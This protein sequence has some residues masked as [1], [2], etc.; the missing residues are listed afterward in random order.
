[1][2]ADASLRPLLGQSNHL[3][4]FNYPANGIQ[5]VSGS[6]PLSSTKGHA[7]GGVPDWLLRDPLR[8]AQGR[9]QECSVMF[10]APCPVVA[11]STIRSTSDH[12]LRMNASWSAVGLGP[13]ALEPNGAM[14]PR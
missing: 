2:L 1:M 3:E 12:P 8:R 5:E 10:S 6:I 7:V 11:R 13:H 9:L 4:S 14:C